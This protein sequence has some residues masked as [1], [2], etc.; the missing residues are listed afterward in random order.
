MRINTGLGLL[1]STALV[2]ALTRLNERRATRRPVEGRIPDDLLAWMDEPVMLPPVS[3]PGVAAAALALGALAIGALAIGALAVGRLEVGRAR[4]R[5][6]EIDDL[7]VRKLNIV[8][9][10]NGDQR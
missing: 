3:S 2:L 5:K 9:A 7:V 4:L 10:N 6:L 1:F 8:E